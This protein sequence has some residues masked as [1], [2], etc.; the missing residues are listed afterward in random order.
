MWDILQPLSCIYFV[1]RH[2][3]IDLRLVT[4]HP[5]TNPILKTPHATLPS[6]S[7]P[8]LRYGCYLQTNVCWDRF[9]VVEQ[10]PNGVNVSIPPSKQKAHWLYPKWSVNSKIKSRWWANATTFWDNMTF[11]KSSMAGFNLALFERPL[12]SPWFDRK[13]IF[14]IQMEGCWKYKKI[15]WRRDFQILPR[16]CKV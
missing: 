13:Y 8:H 2:D 4:W 6:R 3:D 16:D 7:N 12:K 11:S 14:V 5:V 1:V 10:H 15:C 9:E